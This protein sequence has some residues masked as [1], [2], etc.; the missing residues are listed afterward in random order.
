MPTTGIERATFVAFIFITAVVIH[1]SETASEFFVQTICDGEPARTMQCPQ[2][3]VISTIWASYGRQH[4]DMCMADDNQSI[5]ITCKVDYDTVLSLVQEA[6][7]DSNSCSLESNKDVYG[8]PPEC[9]GI[10]K[11]LQVYYLCKSELIKKA[12]C[13][14]NPPENIT[15]PAEQTIQVMEANYGRTDKWTCGE[16]LAD[17][18][19]CISPQ[20]E[21]MVKDKCEGKN[22]CELDASN[23]VFGNPCGVT[24]KYLQVDYHCQAGKV[25]KSVGV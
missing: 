17:N 20:S 15:C 22:L 24:H 12:I 19:Q 3:N 9:Q 14:F 2:Q 7:D 13:E 10:R 8:D 23:E 18:K 5:N 16:E 21:Q 11:Y 1:E 25:V 4:P 6:C